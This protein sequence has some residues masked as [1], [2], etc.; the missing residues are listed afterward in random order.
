MAR[1]LDPESKIGVIKNLEVNGIAKFEN[2]KYM[3]LSV[4]ITNLKKDPLNQD[5]RFKL[6]F[7]DG[8]V[9]VKRIL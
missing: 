6:S 9:I 5:K 4:Q 7:E 2:A 8:V 3:S 1:T